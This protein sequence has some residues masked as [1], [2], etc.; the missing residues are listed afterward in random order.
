MG[1]GHHDVAWLQIPVQNVMAMC[2]LQR[3]RNLDRHM[4]RVVDG[5]FPRL[6]A[7]FQPDGQRL[8]FDIFQHQVVGTDIVDLADM[9]MIQRRYRTR[10]LLESVTLLQQALHRNETMETGVSSLPYLAHATAAKW[11]E[12]LVRAEADAVR[13]LHARCLD[14]GGDA[15]IGTLDP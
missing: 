5:G 9:W 8:P 13:Q 4:Q 11:F 14:E 3:T 7:A 6:R 12:H 2:F 15:R 10:F 1:E